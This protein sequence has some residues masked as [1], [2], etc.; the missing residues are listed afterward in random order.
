ML[1]D[2]TLGDQAL[3]LPRSQASVEHVAGVDAS[4]QASAAAEASVPTSAQ[5]VLSIKNHSGQGLKRSQCSLPLA[6]EAYATEM[7]SR[8]AV[9]MATSRSNTTLLHSAAALTPV[10]G[11][12]TRAA[13][14]AKAIS[15]KSEKFVDGN[16]GDVPAV[17][18]IGI[19]TP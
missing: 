3:P 1:Y 19:E 5:M 10:H 18:S 11:S 6:L 13:A 14:A 9:K 17:K 7:Q 2:S 15:T 8:A 4:M 12:I 16:E